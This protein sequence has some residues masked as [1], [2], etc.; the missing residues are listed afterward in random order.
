M[1]INKNNNENM[2]K[3]NF[4][5]YKMEKSMKDMAKEATNKLYNRSRSEITQEGKFDPFY[6]SFTHEG[7][8]YLLFVSPSADKNYPKERILSVAYEIEDEGNMMSI[9]LKRGDKQEIL[10]YLGNEKNLNEIISYAK[11]TYE[12]YLNS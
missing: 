11:F 10:D 12:K 3:T 8:K 9:V 5:G 1:Q 4:K 6:E 7:K 2:V